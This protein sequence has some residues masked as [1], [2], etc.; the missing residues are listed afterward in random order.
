MRRISVQP[1]HRSL[2]AIP[3]PTPCASIHLFRITVLLTVALFA[4]GLA[5]GAGALPHESHVGFFYKIT[6]L[7]PVLYLIL[8]IIFVLSVV[9]II[10][11][12]RISEPGRVSQQ[13]AG[14]GNR[15]RRTRPGAG[16]IRVGARKPDA[17]GVDIAGQ[18][19]ERLPLTEE[20]AES[21]VV[22]LSRISTRTSA[23]AVSEPTPLDGINHPLPTLGARFRAESLAVE[24]PDA[25]DDERSPSRPFRFTSAVE[26]PSKEDAEK[27]EKE[28][29]VVAGA[30]RDLDGKGISSVLVYLTDAG[31]NRVGQ[32][33]RTIPETGEFKVQVNKP[34]Q[35][36]LHG[37]KRGLM[38]DRAKPEPLPMEAGRIDGY[39]L[40]MVPEGCV[41]HGSLLLEPAKGIPSGLVVRC[42]VKERDDLSLSGAVDSEAAFRIVGVP[43]ESACRLEVRDSGG[44]LLATTQPFEIGRESEF[45]HDIT[46]PAPQAC[47]MMPT[48]ESPPTGT[49]NG[50]HQSLPPDGASSE[51]KFTHTRPAP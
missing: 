22:S 27:R 51:G 4:S 23:A 29:L 46:I 19:A 44:E 48:T 16:R 12:S 42:F 30:V 9:N 32:S 1:K 37:Y 13:R 47:C 8:F 38:V 45:R 20:M 14:R 41:V 17:L 7:H 36:Y 43:T 25:A 40:I 26:L 18:L 50:D 21:G 39:S 33:C 24:K 3:C 28:K 5:A 31:G 10:Y 11:Q 34:G 6:H 35:Y 15:E 2:V 49:G